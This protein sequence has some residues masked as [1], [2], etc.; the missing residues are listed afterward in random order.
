MSM[1]GLNSE[2]NTASEKENLQVVVF[3]LGV[4]E[5]A[6]DILNVQEIN[7]V[8]TI[9]RVPRTEQYIEGVMNL[10]GNIIPIINLYTRFSLQPLGNEEDSRII[11]FQIDELKIGVIVDEVVEVVHVNPQDIEEA[12][13]LYDSANKDHILGV[14]KNNDRLLILLDLNKIMD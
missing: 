6:V 8:L 1:I 14:I 4:E 2:D 12:D 11:V 9:T 5:Y 13:K 3:K 7:K 10:R